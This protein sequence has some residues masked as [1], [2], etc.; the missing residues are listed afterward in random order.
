[1][2]LAVQSVQK[3]AYGNLQLSPRTLQNG[4][5]CF[6]CTS[7]VLPP[8]AEAERATGVAVRG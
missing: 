3:T 1:M 5:G 6:E 4:T 2:E 7:N 8:V